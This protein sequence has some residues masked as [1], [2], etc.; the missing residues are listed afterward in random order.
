MNRDTTSFINI[1]SIV[2]NVIDMDYVCS[3][4]TL[5]EA[6]GREVNA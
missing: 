5:Q 1:H 3:V 2:P 6:Q 4:S